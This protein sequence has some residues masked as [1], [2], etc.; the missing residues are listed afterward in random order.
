MPSTYF[1]GR[2]DSKNTDDQRSAC[3]SPPPKTAESIRNLAVIAHVDHGKTT[4]SDALLHRAGLI[5]RKRAGDQDTGRSL[6]TLPDEKERGITIK[7]AA[8]TLNMYVQAAAMEKASCKFAKKD[9]E[10]ELLDFYVGNLPRGMIQPSFVS[11]LM[12]SGKVSENDNLRFQH[13]N[14]HR[15]FAILRITESLASSLC[16]FAVC[17]AL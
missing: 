4:L 15:G 9:N 2:N 5:S 3:C 16:G 14:S 17:E 10:E 11:Y 13:W 8:V 6:D 12:K 1:E 7:S